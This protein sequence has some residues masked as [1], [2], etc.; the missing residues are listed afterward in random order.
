MIGNSDDLTHK[1]R[2]PVKFT[3]QVDPLDEGDNTVKPPT[4]GS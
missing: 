1:F 3:H 2:G 4:L